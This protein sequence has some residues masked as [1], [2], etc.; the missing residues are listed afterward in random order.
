ME[1]FNQIAE[2][3]PRG[4]ALNLFPIWIRRAGGKPVL[5]RVGWLNARFLILAP[6]EKFN[7]IAEKCPRGVVLNFFPVLG[8]FLAPMVIFPFNQPTGGLLRTPMI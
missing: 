4:V 6:L 8:Q 3:C 5:A 2:K 1:K 7:Q